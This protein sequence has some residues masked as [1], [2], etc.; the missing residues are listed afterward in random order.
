[1]KKLLLGGLVLATVGS[2]SWGAYYNCNQVFSYPCGQNVIVE[3]LDN[4]PGCHAGTW[5]VFT[6]TWRGCYYVFGAPGSNG[7]Q[8]DVDGQCG[9]VIVSVDCAGNFG[10]PMA[11]NYPHSQTTITGPC[12]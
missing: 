11:D 9:E 2:V 3:N 1:M 7:C 4:P 12:S 8:P 10:T 5:Y 6:G